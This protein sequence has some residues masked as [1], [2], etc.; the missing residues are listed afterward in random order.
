MRFLPPRK[1]NSISVTMI[2]LLVFREIIVFYREYQTKH[3]GLCALCGEKSKQPM[4]LGQLTTNLWRLT[5]NDL[6]DSYVY[7]HWLFCKS[8]EIW[9]R[10]QKGR[11]W[12]FVLRKPSV[13]IS[14]KYSLLLPR[15]L[16]VL[17]ALAWPKN[18][19]WAGPCLSVC[20][21]FLG[22]R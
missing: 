1:T 6:V 10:G 19:L 7:L 12:F 14:V 18:T 15:I 20:H 17:H 3:T 11:K 9:S 22:G 8:D 2:G 13:R 4:H 5:A 21:V 16:D